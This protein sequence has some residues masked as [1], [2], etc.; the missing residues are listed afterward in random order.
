V[1]KQD[2]NRIKQ[3]DFLNIDIKSV[4][5]VVSL[6]NISKKEMIQVAFRLSNRE[7]DM[8]KVG[9]KLAAIQAKQANY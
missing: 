5:D 7:K 1:D 2:Y 9:G 6:T 3:G 4:K 8:I